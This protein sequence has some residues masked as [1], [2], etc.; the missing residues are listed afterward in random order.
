MK[1]RHCSAVPANEAKGGVLDVNQK[2]GK[3]TVL[4]ILKEKHP[5]PQIINQDYTVPNDEST[6]RYYPSIFEKINASATKA[7]M[8]LL[9]STRTNGAGFWQ[10]SRRHPLT[11]VK[12]SRSLQSG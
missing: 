2:I 10:P 3:S 6:L 7:V 5:S 9:E 8:V 1:S 4:D 12:S 11:F